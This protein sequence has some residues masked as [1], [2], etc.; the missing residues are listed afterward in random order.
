MT[1]NVINS[2]DQVWFTVAG[3]DKADAVEVAFSDSPEALPVG[4]VRGTAKTVWFVDK[5]AAS[6]TAAI[7]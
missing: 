7:N 5:A 1:Y 4:R 2:A 3:A 6:K